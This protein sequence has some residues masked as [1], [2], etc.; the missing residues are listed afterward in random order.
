[1]AGVPCK[2]QECAKNALTVLSKKGWIQFRDVA[3]YVPDKLIEGRGGG[4]A[5]LPRPSCM[6]QQYRKYGEGSGQMDSFGDE[7]PESKNTP[8]KVFDS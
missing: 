7:Q 5:F 3:E 8:F 6:C 4:C 2:R 1:M